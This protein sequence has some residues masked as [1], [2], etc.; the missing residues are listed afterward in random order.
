MAETML[1]SMTDGQID[2]LANKLRDAARKHREEFPREVTQEVLRSK[3]IGMQLLTTFRTLVEQASKLIVRHVKVSRTLTPAQAIDGTG[4]TKWYIVE[5]VLAEMPLDGKVEDDVVVFELNYDPTVDELD[6][7]Y[8]ARGL[9]PDPAAVAQ[10]MADEPALAD[11]RP[12]AVQ[13]RDNQGRACC[14]LFGR[15]GDERRVRVRWLVSGWFRSFRFAGV[16]K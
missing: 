3:N 12:V 10:A 7:E 13:W 1:A 14:A 6:R 15:G 9:R 4:R 16:R 2:D 5:E 8:K 11:E